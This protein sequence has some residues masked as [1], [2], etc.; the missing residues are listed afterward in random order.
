[1]KMKRKIYILGLI[2]GLFTSCEKFLD[3]PP[4]NQ[5]FADAYYKNRDEALVALNSV[6]VAAKETDFLV[7]GPLR[8]PT[9]YNRQRISGIQPQPLWSYTHNSNDAPSSDMWRVN[10]RV[11]AAANLLIDN[12]ERNQATVTGFKDIVGQAKV[13]RAI[14]YF[15]LVRLFGDVPLI[16]EGKIVFDTA[17]LNVEQA[18]EAAIYEQIIQDLEYA[19]ANCLT[20]SAV[21]FGVITKGFAAGLLAKVYL[22]LGSN[23]QRDKTGDGILH[24][25]KCMN[26]CLKITGT[27]L[28]GTG[29]YGTYKLLDYYPDNFIRETK[30]ND[31]SLWSINYEDGPGLGGQVGFVTGFPG[32]VLQGGV[33]AGSTNATEYA[34]DVLFDKSDSVRRFWTFERAQLILKDGKYE[35][36]TSERQVAPAAT[37]SRIM[38]MPIYYRF[39]AAAIT[40]NPTFPPVGI[41]KYRRIPRLVTPY[42][43][44]Q[45]GMNLPVMRYAEVLLMLAE[46]SAEVAGGPTEMSYKAVNLVRDRAR[47][48]NR[49]PAGR[50]GV[51]EDIYPRQLYKVTT[52]VPDFTGMSASVFKEAILNERSRELLCEWN[53]RWFDLV[54]IG[55]LKKRINELVSY[56]NLTFG[57]VENDW[58]QIGQSVQD[59]HN[60]LPIPFTDIQLNPKLK[61]NPGY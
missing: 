49:A 6:Y 4:E 37:A 13:L 38:T 34:V 20:K 12:V 60:K 27:G 39:G 41:G 55:E 22:T 48:N 43:N 36:Q 3:V 26:Q 1:M 31:E 14:A 29:D 10:Y 51:R 17:L 58:T 54:R 61:Q 35:L 25:T 15:N 56:Q 11:I 33:F 53:V 40:N 7:A 9:D 45:Y 28:T 46:A 47:W 59:F 42:F 18:K 24:F 5:V 19:E 50:N 32:E 57:R 44:T 8:L 21:S 2:I 16:L 30:V 23:E 52:N